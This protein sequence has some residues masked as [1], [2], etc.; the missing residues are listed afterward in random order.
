MR[1]GLRTSMLIAFLVAGPV[2]TAA[3]Q[4][5]DGAAAWRT[6]VRVLASPRCL[7]CHPG[8]DTPTQADDMHRHRPPVQRGVHDAGIAA[9]RC[10]TCHADRNQE[11]AGVPGAPH[12]HLAPAAM[13][14]AGLTSGALC[15]RIKDRDRNGNRSVD[16]LVAHMTGDAL[17]RWAWTP[18]GRRTPP[19]VPFD[20]FATALETWA[21]A[22][23]PCAD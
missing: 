1:A 5:A 22:G 20:D 16:A 8:G 14:W 4:S 7:N 23:A 11:I 19:P 21:K 18:G 6:I 9:M 12:W 10:T 13:G 2:A 17:V 3:A 15:R